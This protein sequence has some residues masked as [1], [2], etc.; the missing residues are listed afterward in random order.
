MSGFNQWQKKTHAQE[1]L[2]YPKNIGQNLAIDET[3][4]SNGELY[5]ILT[6]KDKKGK[7]GSIVG[8]FK[9]TQSDQ[10]ISLIKEHIKKALRKMV[11]EVTLDMAG[12]MNLIVKKCF[13]KADATIDRFHVQQLAN[14]AVQELRIKYRWDV[15]D[16]EHAA[17]K[18]AKVKQRAY[19]PEILENGD[20]LKQLMA[21]SRYALYKSRDKW[22]DSQKMRVR[23]LFERYP[24]IELA[25]QLSDGLRKIYN[26][27]I[28]P[29]TA[30]LKLARWFD[31]IEKA[32]LNSFNSIK[33]T[34]EVHHKQIVNFFIRRS[35]NA[36][37]ESFNAKIK[38]FRRTFRGVADIDFFL[39]RLTKIYA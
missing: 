21:R 7:K 30:R 13:P 26:Q 34:F 4:L 22:T 8:I 9:G 38:D 14:D 25:Y 31:Q 29:N 37:A 16:R 12:S 17:Y 35:T 18:K 20:T 1:Y 24:D 32:G 36:S 2:I 28:E 6:N 39:F 33:R 10:I 5:T 19:Q 3:S 11:K 15:I 23:L 27:A